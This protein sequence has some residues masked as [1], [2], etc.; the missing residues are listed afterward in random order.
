MKGDPENLKFTLVVFSF[1]TDRLKKLSPN[2][3]VHLI[4]DSRGN[5]T[6]DHCCGKFCVISWE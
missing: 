4:I 2:L 6:A 1:V 5:Y 3:Y